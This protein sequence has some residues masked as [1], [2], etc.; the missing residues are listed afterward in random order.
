MEAALADTERIRSLARLGAEFRL[1]ALRKEIDEVL[2][3]FPELKQA[4]V[5]SP[6]PQASAAAPRGR[7]RKR[8][9][10]TPEQRAAVSEWMRKYWA[11][12][13]QQRAAAGRGKTAG[14]GSATAKAAGRSDRGVKAPRP[15]AQKGRPAART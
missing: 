11:G 4:S 7:A 13:R 12:R 14:N 15:S 9:A 8:R 5:K 1:N 6:A 2:Q 3:L 10:M